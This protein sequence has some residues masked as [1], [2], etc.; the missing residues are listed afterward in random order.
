MMPEPLILIKPTIFSIEAKPDA[1]ERLRSWLC[2][3]LGRM[4]A[5]PNKS[6]T[7]HLIIDALNRELNVNDIAIQQFR[8]Q[9]ESKKQEETTVVKLTVRE[10]QL[11]DFIIK[12]G[13]NLEA[14]A[15]NLQVSVHTVKSHKTAIY[16]KLQV[17]NITD[18]VVK[19]IRLKLVEV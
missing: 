10:K 14:L 5:E 17:G 12:E 15:K 19:A 13:Y 8:R 6:P 2:L 3:V 1:T 7:E 18:A 4:Q 11:L 9:F 16:Q